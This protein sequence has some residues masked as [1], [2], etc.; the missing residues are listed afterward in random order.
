MSRSV[1]RFTVVVNDRPQTLTLAGDPLHVA[2]ARLGVGQHAQHVVEFWCEVDFPGGALRGFRRS[3]NGSSRCSA[4][5]SSS[6]TGRCGV[7]PR[8]GLRRGWSG[9][10][11]SCRRA[12]NER[13]G[14]TRYE[15]EVAGGG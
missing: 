1:L 7:A 3:V 2:A 9:I 14:R 13:N 8:A 6:R 10:C 15:I 5:A 12:T 11:T 4:P